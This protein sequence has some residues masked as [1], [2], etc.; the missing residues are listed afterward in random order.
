MRVRVCVRVRVAV[1]EYVYLQESAGDR[2]RALG[3]AAVP[4]APAPAARGRPPGAVHVGVSA[5]SNACSPEIKGSSPN[6]SRCTT[7][8]CGTTSVSV[9]P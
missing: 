2:D 6:I 8:G 5:I 7:T 4:A 3:L 9:S 1:V